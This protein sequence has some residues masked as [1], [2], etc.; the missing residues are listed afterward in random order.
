MLAAGVVPYRPN[1]DGLVVNGYQYYAISQLLRRSDPNANCRLLKFPQ[2][3]V[4]FRPTKASLRQVGKNSS[5]FWQLVEREH[6]HARAY[7]SRLTGNSGDGDDLYQDAVIKAFNGFAGLRQVDSFRPW[8]YQIINNT[9]KGRVRNPWWKYVWARPTEIMDHDWSHDPTNLYEA[10]R[11]LDSAMSALNIDDRIIV[12]LA[13]LEGW[14]I[15]ELAEL[16]SKTEGFIKM[17]LSRART[18][19]RKRLGIMQRKTIGLHDKEEQ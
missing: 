6:E 7:C 10:R 12:T 16:T 8:L 4:T 11:R 1:F 17:R 13:E 18:K 3:I 5:P 2:I 15:S 9:Y 14:K 19:M